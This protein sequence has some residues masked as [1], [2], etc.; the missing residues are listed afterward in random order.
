MNRYLQEKGQS[1]CSKHRELPI[2]LERM[3]I[4]RQYTNLATMCVCKPIQG[5]QLNGNEFI[6]LDNERFLAIREDYSWNGMTWFWDANEIMF[7]TLVHDA[8]NQLM[9][10]DYGKFSNENRIEDRSKFRKEADKFFYRHCRQNRV[11][12]VKA[13]ICYIGVWVA[14]SYFSKATKKYSYKVNDVTAPATLTDDQ[15]ASV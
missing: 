7:P 3:N 9:R 15:F 4:A 2:V 10:I 12:C 6:S 5:Q 14:G 8:L 1:K 11:N 13:L